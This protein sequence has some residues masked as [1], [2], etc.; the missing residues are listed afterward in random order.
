MKIILEEGTELEK[1][2]FERK[3]VERTED[4]WLFLWVEKGVFQGRG[5]GKNLQEIFKT[6]LRWGSQKTFYCTE[7]NSLG[8]LE[9]WYSENCDGDWEHTWGINIDLLD[10]FF[11]SVQIDLKE[12][13][14]EEKFFRERMVE[15]NE[16]NFIHCWV[17]EQT[18]RGCGGPKNLSEILNIFEKWRM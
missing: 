16:D 7:M 13:S 1:K 8:I 6:F 18:F 2:D 17:D 14:I 12:T 11:W 10:K 15:R 5:G 9:D 3:E 4:D